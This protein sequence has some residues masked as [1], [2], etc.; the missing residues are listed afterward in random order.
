MEEILE[1]FPTKEA[2]EEFWNAN[3]EPITYD[4]VKEAYEQYVKDAEKHIFLSD[5]EA[6]SAIS[7]EDFMD[8]LSEEAAFT[9]QDALTEAF[10]D[11]NPKVYEAAFALFEASQMEGNAALDVA[12]A[13]HLEYNRLYKEF[14]LQMFDAFF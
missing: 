7:R 13:F 9:F 10:Y 14:M 12:E 4:E 8:N 3:Y 2:F 11:K 6:D 1:Q 5:Y